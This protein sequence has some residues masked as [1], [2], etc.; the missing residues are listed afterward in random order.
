MPAKRDKSR[1]VAMT[2]MSKTSSPVE[3]LGL[4]L[5]FVAGTFVRL[6]FISSHG[7]WDTEYWKAWASETAR[8]G[9]TQAYGGPDSVPP[10]DF[11]PQ[12]LAQK[13]RH[14]VSFRDRDYPI[15]YPPLG[16]AAWGESWRFFTS[17]PRPYRGDAAENL[18]VK[19]PAVLGDV[20]AVVVLLWAFRGDPRLALSLGVVYWIFPITWV[21]SA[22][23]GFFDGFVP[24]FLLVS[25]LLV[26]T[27]PFLA[28]AAFAVTCLIKP[29]A[30]VALPVLFLALPKSAWPKVIGGGAIVT[31]FVLLPYVFAG[32]LETAIIHV[33]RLFS[34]D[35]ISGGYANPWWVFGHAS[36]V[37]SGKAV[38]T[39][40]VAY[41]RRDAFDLPFGLIGFLAA[42]LVAVWVLSVARRIRSARSVVYVSALLLFIWGV[43]TIGVHDNHNHPLFLLLI[44][45]GLQTAFL[46]RFA[47]AAAM[48]TL[49]G[50]ICLHGLGRFYGT[51]WRAVLPLAD[52][53]AGLRMAFG[54]DLT[55]LLALLN[56]ALLGF[57]LWRLKETL[58]D[59][60]D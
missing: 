3:H 29:T 12:L 53:V 43:L 45:T 5:A 34:Q 39:D 24:P 8:V 37:L 15:D 48:S 19:F 35:R 28:G 40:Q 6:Y 20:L 36:M 50:S 17:K 52:T 26:P 31:T 42:G 59:L 21:S 60:E 58:R 1:D 56:C 9:V 55:L 51:E 18:A 46:K 30:A 57:A 49:L 10:G 54:F 2:W 14:E 23:L 32:T 25:L 27:A 22:V 44:A 13:P 4:A 7:S 16:L 41:V 38:W 11:F 33:G 47:F